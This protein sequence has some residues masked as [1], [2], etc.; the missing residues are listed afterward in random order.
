MRLLIRCLI[1]LGFALAVHQASAKPTNKQ[2]TSVMR[3]T[4]E[5]VVRP[6]YQ[7][8]EAQTLQLQNQVSQLCTSPSRAALIGVHGQFTKVA[9][10]WASI[11]LFRSGPVMDENRLERVLF[12]PDRKSTGLKQVQRILANADSS[13]IASNT[14][15]GKSVAVQ[16]LGALE[17]LLFGTG[18]AVL[19]AEPNS[20]RCQFASSITDNLNSI[21]TELNSA[22][23]SEYSEQWI[24]AGQKDSVFINDQEAV[25][26]LLGTVVHSLEAIKDIRLKAF[27]RKE[28][29]RD[30]PKSALFWRSENTL[31]MMRANLDFVQS[32]LRDGGLYSF[33]GENKRIVEQIEFELKHNKSA[34][35]A[36]NGSLFDALKDNTLRGKLAYFG[37]SLKFTITRI[38]QEFAQKL[39][40]S[41]GFSFSDGD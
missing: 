25:N 21:A 22:W 6:A 38:D 20:F 12:Y 28:A 5:N 16:G 39:G 23:S 29:T 4:V 18:Y 26:E 8:F 30:R 41:S 35:D 37:I 19:S 24:N 27:L 15:S 2:I 40:L 1:S 3:Q 11:E 9:R 7:N 36:V 31:S 10:S 14:I 13:A 17:F 32:M 34:I 33:A